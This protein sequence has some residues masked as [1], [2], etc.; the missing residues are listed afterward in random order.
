MLT[1]NVRGLE[2]LPYVS[3]PKMMPRDGVMPYLLNTARTDMRTGTDSA[4][5]H[6]R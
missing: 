4:C 2:V 1:S 5:A 3:G 6:G